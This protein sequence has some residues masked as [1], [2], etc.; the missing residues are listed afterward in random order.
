MRF[1]RRDKEVADGKCIYLIYTMNLLAFLVFVLIVILAI[2][3][4]VGKLSHQHTG[5]KEIV[6]VDDSRQKPARKFGFSGINYVPYENNQISA[7]AKTRDPSILARLLNVLKIRRLP[8]GNSD[9]DIL[10][11]VAKIRG[12]SAAKNKPQWS[13]GAKRDKHHAELLYNFAKKYIKFDN[14]CYLDFGGADCGV[15]SFFGKLIKAKETNCFDIYPSEVRHVG[16]IR[17]VGKPGKSLPY[18]DNSMNV[19]TAIMSLHHVKDL[20]FMAKEIE[21]VMAPGAFLIIREHDCW[22]AADAMIVDIE[23]KLYQVAFDEGMDNNVF[24]YRNDN[25]WENLFNLKLIVKNYYFP[26]PKP[27]I[28]ASRAFVAIFQKPK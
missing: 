1:K 7:L 4:I 5:S 16:V 2:I 23:H 26:R 20:L 18:G 11:K 19:I 24:H 22:D 13:A 15:S 14:F 6:I 21:R 3:I 9:T 28:T 17:K 8:K 27:N 25:S 10:N 12:L